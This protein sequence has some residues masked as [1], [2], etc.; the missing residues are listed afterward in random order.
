MNKFGPY[1]GDVRRAGGHSNVEVFVQTVTHKPL[2][3]SH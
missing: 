3:I 2:D 1:I